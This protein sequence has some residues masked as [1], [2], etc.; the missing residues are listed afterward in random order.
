VAR[1]SPLE[2]IEALTARLVELEAD[3]ERAV[4]AAMER[5]ATWAEI[6]EALGV[7]AQA[8]HKRY[9]WLRHSQLTGECWYEPP[10]AGVTRRARG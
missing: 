8:A 6:G 10:L 7:T 9:R 3:R 2:K 5:G 1:R 4:A